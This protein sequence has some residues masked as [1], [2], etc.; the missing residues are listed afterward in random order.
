[1]QRGPLRVVL[2]TRS[3]VVKDGKL[4]LIRRSPTDNYQPGLWE[5]PGGK[6]EYSQ[7]LSDSRKREVE[8][9]TGFTTALV[10]SLSFN[11]SHVIANGRYE[12]LL[13]LKIFNITRVT[14]GEFKLSEEHDAFAWV[15]Y[16]EMLTYRLSS[17]VR[18]AAKVLRKLLQKVAK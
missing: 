3:F 1:M 18:N 16:E 14:G 10:S 11:D 6:A 8:E 13:S 12:G 2:V 15:S 9:E 5:C 7:E 4:L 17:E